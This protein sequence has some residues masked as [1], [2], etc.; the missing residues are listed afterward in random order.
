MYI[1]KENK[2]TKIVILIIKD[3]IKDKKYI[4]EDVLFINLTFLINNIFIIVKLDLYI[5]IHFKKLN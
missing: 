3:K 1:S 5:N 2:I 4:K